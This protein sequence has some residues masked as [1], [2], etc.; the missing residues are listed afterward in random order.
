MNKLRLF[1]L[2]LLAAI[3]STPLFAQQ[4]QLPCQDPLRRVRIAVKDAGAGQDSIWFGYDRTATCG[5]DTH[6]CEIHAIGSP[7]SGVFD[8]RWWRRPPCEAGYHRDYLPYVSRTRVDTHS[9]TFQPSGGGYPMS[10]HWRHEDVQAVCDSA[11][12]RDVFGGILVNVRMREVDSLVV[13]SPAIVSLLLIQ[14]GQFPT[15]TEPSPRLTMAFGDN[16]DGKDTLWFA[17]HP[18]ATCG[19]D[20]QL[21]EGGVVEPPPP[22]PPGI[23]YV[24]W[25][26]GSCETGTKR[27]YFPVA[28]GATDSLWMRVQPGEAGYPIR[29][30]WDPGYFWSLAD[31]AVLSD[32]FGGILF[33][34]R[35]DLIDSLVVTNPEIAGLQMVIWQHPTSVTQEGEMP[36]FALYQNYPNPFNPGTNLEFHV[37]HLSHVLLNVYD[38]LGRKVATL[39]D[40]VKSP[41]NYRVTLD[42]SQLAGGVYVYRLMAGEYVRSG[43]ALLIK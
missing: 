6:L 32:M 39:V 28:H 9:V 15:C 10:F 13:I 33:R 42:G 11:I 12:L 30:K 2:L 41:G 5:V 35:M 36:G 16:G 43:K 22:P 1:L 23:F 25:T 19:M 29:V 26:G 17:I 20:T 18:L 21:C 34:C 3:C 7:P 40:E 14:Y 8:V 31:S 38:L 37:A 4:T 24:S 27:A